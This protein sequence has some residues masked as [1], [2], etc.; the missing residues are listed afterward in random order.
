MGEG[1]CTMQIHPPITC[2]TCSPMY[3]SLHSDAYYI[4]L[5]TSQQLTPPSLE[6][7]CKCCMPSRQLLGYGYGG[8]HNWSGH[9]TMY[10]DVVRTK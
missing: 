8:Q 6:R 10:D 4:D 2:Q 3:K 9:T 5:P 1:I 7:A